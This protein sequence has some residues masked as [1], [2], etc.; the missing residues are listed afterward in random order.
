VPN[1]RNSNTSHYLI[2]LFIKCKQ[3]SNARRKV[4]KYCD[5]CKCVVQ[6]GSWA[7]HLT[8]KKYRLNSYVKQPSDDTKH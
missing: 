7:G 6:W 3:C 8:S 4:K 5:S 2:V 1:V